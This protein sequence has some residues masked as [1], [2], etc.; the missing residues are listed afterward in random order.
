MNPAT[1]PSRYSTG[2]VVFDTSRCLGYPHWL[3]LF[4]RES[5]TN[6]ALTALEKR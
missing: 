4:R 6:Y 2:S 3:T 1:P 5:R